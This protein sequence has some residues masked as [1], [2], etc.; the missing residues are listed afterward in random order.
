MSCVAALWYVWLARNEMVFE[1]KSWEV[2]D[3]LFLVKIQSLF[4]I[5]AI[6][7]GG[8]VVESAWW[9]NPVFCYFDL[10][11]FKG[12]PGSAG[13]GWVLRDANGTILAV[14]FAPLGL[15]DSNM[16]ELMAIKMALDVFSQT[17]WMN[18]V[19]LIIELNF[20]VAINWCVK[21]EGRLLRLWDTLYKIDSGVCKNWWC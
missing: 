20:L 15:L 13:C 10:P 1:R 16:A 7:E 12:K 18:I 6:A 17:Q 4:W 8:C 11:R 2:D 21:M 14:F 9:G 19:K 5:K 3:I